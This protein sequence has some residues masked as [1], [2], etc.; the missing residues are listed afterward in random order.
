MLYY[1]DNSTEAVTYDQLERH[2]RMYL[3]SATQSIALDWASTAQCRTTYKDGDTTIKA[4]S[5]DCYEFDKFKR[6]A[7]KD[8]SA[9]ARSLFDALGRS[10][11]QVHKIAATLAEGLNLMSE[12]EMWEVHVKVSAV[13]NKY[14]S[15]DVCEATQEKEEDI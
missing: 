14:F 3:N 8:M 2:V 6:E 7:T 9:D 15:T 13:M 10:I 1:I 5:T 4:V 11:V 12:K